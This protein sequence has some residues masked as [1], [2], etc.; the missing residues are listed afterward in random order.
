MRF[1]VEIVDLHQAE[2]RLTIVRDALNGKLRLF[3]S[4][5]S[6][7]IVA[8][9]DK[10][11]PL[12]LGTGRY[13]RPV[14]I[15]AAYLLPI[16]LIIHAITFWGRGIIDNEAMEFVLNYLL[17]RPLLAQIFDPAV[18]DWGA[19]QARELS[20][21]FDLIDA[22]VFAFLLD[23]H[24]LVFVPLSGVLGLIAFSAVY[25]W[26]ARKIFGLTGVMT[27][28]LL[29]LF[30][31][32]I[33]VQA[34][35]PVFYRSAKI[36][37]SIALLA[38]LFYTFSIVRSDK[39]NLTALKCATL[40]LLGLLMA[41]CDRQGFYYLVSTTVVLLMLWLTAKPRTV[42]VE[43]PYLRVILV[44]TGAIGTTI[45]YNRI[46]APNLIHALNGYWPNFWYQHLPW[47]E[48]L[49]P[50]LPVKAWYFFQQ[51]VSFFF[52]NVPFALLA[53]IIAIAA[54]LIVR[55][56]RAMINVNNLTVLA[57]SLA[58]IAAIFVLIVTM[59]ARHPDIYS[60]RD[61]SFWY[62]T[63]T[64][65]VVILFG[66]SAWLS[67]F[68]PADRSLFNPLFH[69]LIVILIG[70]NVLAYARQR[71]IMIHSTE[72]FGTQYEHSQAF[73]AQFATA[74]PAR[75]KLLR[76]SNDLFWDDEAHYLEN[77]ERAYLHFTGASRPDPDTQ[78]P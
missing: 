62:Y 34:S 11:R 65:Q 19:Y 51:Q 72:W 41:L 13:S 26:G 44:N 29:S 38:F 70:S 23:R 5:F 20:Y 16:A 52:G 14:L 74:P 39:R 42:I 40:F 55:K 4:S 71:Q 69:A 67:F 77:V 73:A 24:L 32:C 7:Q 56:R 47:S 21:L 28:M 30:L 18:N 36:I 61:H 1:D 63:L 60:I 48:F 10:F 15:A 6:I 2:V 50:S 49:D 58:S 33:V 22:R 53:A 45:F 3:S 54:L 17:K 35:T 57:V 43:H 8:N 12:A 31:S 27:N 46:F 78:Q 59:I 66:I 37:L 75:E 64:I 25:Y 68:A 9:L 76:N